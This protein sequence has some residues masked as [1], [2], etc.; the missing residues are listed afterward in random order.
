ML[1]GEITLINNHYYYNSVGN[2]VPAIIFILEFIASLNYGMY[3]FFFRI[4]FS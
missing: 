1:S 2:D 4:N 3:F